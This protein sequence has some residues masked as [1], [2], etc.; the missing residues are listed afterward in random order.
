[1][2]VQV[3]VRVAHVPLRPLFRKVDV[4][5]PGKGNGARP[6][7]LIIAM[8][9]WTR[10]SRLSIKNPLSEG[11]RTLKPMEM[12][13]RSGEAARSAGSSRDDICRAFL[14][15]LYYSQA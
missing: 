6:V 13:I 4:R 7:H 12:K 8:I 9:K 2:A 1:M 14:L 3:E 10:T 15:L 11:G 5:L